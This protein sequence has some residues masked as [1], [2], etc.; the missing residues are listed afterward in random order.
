MLGVGSEG[1]LMCLRREWG[2]GENFTMEE[3]TMVMIVVVIMNDES[4]KS[5]YLF[6]HWAKKTPSFP[7]V[8]HNND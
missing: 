6:L 8:C 7:F 4:G 1:G 2:R 3:R 5:N